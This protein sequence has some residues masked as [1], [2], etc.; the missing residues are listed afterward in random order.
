MTWPQAIL[1]WAPDQGAS[2][3]ALLWYTRVLVTK[4]L[5]GSL[6]FL[7]VTFIQRVTTSGFTLSKLLT[8][9]LVTELT[10]AIKFEF[11]KETLELAWKQALH[12][13][14]T[15]SHMLFREKMHKWRPGVLNS[16]DPL[17]SWI[18]GM[19]V[20][21]SALWGENWA[22]AF[23]C[24]WEQEVLGDPWSSVSEAEDKEDEETPGCFIAGICNLACTPSTQTI[25]SP[26]ILLPDILMWLISGVA[27]ALGFLCSQKRVSWAALQISTL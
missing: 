23:I 5:A 15:L 10:A 16:Y 7:R 26:G 27:G 14:K 19:G 18:S 3:W 13:R 11:C 6:L 9:N 25:S 8:D 24:L 12:Q 20:E 21:P 22:C 1:L 2:G 17:P 4:T